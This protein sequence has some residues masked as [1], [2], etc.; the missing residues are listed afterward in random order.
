MR[1]K[2]PGST[3]PLVPSWTTTSWPSWPASFSC[4]IRSTPAEN[5]RL[6]A[7]LTPV[8]GWLPNMALTVAAS[9]LAAPSITESPMAVT[10]VGGRV[11]TGG[12][13]VAGTVVG[14]VAP[15]AAVV[16]VV[17]PGRMTTEVLSP[18]PAGAAALPPSPRPTTITT[19][20]R[21]I[22][23]AASPKRAASLRRV[24]PDEVRNRPHHR[25]SAP[26]RTGSSTKRYDSAAA[27]ERQREPE[28]EERDAG[29]GDVGVRARDHVDRPVPQVDAVRAHADPAEHVGGEEPRHRAATRGAPSPR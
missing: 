2:S 26:W 18:S 25:S 28:H 21:V 8:T 20:P 16:V 4:W 17:C 22:P 9:W 3:V 14:V 23:L 5:C 1:S 6:S 11:V 27:H 7:A 24:S 13:V 19:R 29:Q 12:A 15:G 10:V